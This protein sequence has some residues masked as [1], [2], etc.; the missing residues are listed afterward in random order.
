MTTDRRERTPG[1]PTL[2]DR[3]VH[4]ATRRLPEDQRA[5]VADEL[6]GSIDDRVEALLDERP[7]LTPEQA[8]YAALEELGEP[9][10][11]S[12]GYSGRKLRLIGPELFPSYV[13][14]LKGT[15]LVVPVVALVVATIDAL[16]GGDV[17]SVVGA[18]VW[19]AYTVAVQVAFWVT[20]VFAV[21]ER[22]PDDDVRE[23]VGAVWTPDQLPEL[24][25]AHRGSVTDLVAALVFLWLFGA[26]IVW[27]QL[28]P[29]VSYDGEDVPV[30]DPEL[31][32]F[33]LPLVL[34][35]IVAE[36]VFE[37]VKYRAG[38]WTTRLA[39]LNVVLGAVFTAPVVYLAASDRLLNP[40]AVA[41]I[42]EHWA[43]FDPDVVG[44]IVVL[45]AVVIYVWD[46][47]DG[48]RKALVA[49]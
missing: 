30:L 43:E 44:L 20:A 15:L 27:Q 10:R 48:W 3:Y 31:W 29:S 2:A 25:R 40:H 41:G 33:W 14:V 17:G 28:N 46:V 34:V 24:S 5:D 11:L 39:T 42:Q 12:A 26:A 13:R 36:M 23:S 22:G 37:V 6:R 9:E 16:G 45:S 8:E 32:T 38:G 1:T 21:V 4:A 47:V 18:A 49:R 35:L 19:T 7:G